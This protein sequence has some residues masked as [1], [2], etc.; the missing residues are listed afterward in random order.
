MKRYESHTVCSCP[1]PQV[2]SDFSLS[3]D[4]S[5]VVWAG[6]GSTAAVFEIVDPA[7]RVETPELQNKFYLIGRDGTR[8][9]FEA[10][11]NHLPATDALPAS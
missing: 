2:F 9:Y 5:E 6:Q 11:H 10:E 8:E 1:R 7:E 3:P 4:S